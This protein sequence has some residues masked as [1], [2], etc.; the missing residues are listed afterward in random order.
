[1]RSKRKNLTLILNLR[2]VKY[3]SIDPFLEALSI[4]P[5]KKQE[6]TIV[7]TTHYMEEAYVLCDEI[8]IIDKG[9]IITHGT[10][11]GLVESHFDDFQIHLP[12]RAFH[13]GAQVIEHELIDD[14]IVIRTKD[15]NQT[16]NQLV[17][18]KAI[19]DEMVIRK[20]TLEDLFLDL[21]GHSL[22]E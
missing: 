22:R 1:M 6:K 8:V 2:K 9:H 20:P 13:G 21:T 7:L 11:K 15:I 18:H 3:F 17:E 4:S 10:P 19:L 12:S 14:T 5:I 16:I